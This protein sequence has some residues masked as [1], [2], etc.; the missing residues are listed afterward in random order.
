MYLTES[1]TYNEKLTVKLSIGGLFWFAIPE[2]KD[3]QNRRIQFGPGVGQAQGV[4]AFGD[5]PKDPAATLQFGLFPHKYSESVNLGE[6][7]Y[8]SGTY[9]GTLTS[10]G[11]SYLNAAAYLAQG[12]RLNVPMLEGKLT[13]DF[14]LYMERD[15]E[16]ANDLSPGY[17]VTYKPAAFL[18]L[19]AGLIWSHA[20][21]LNSDRLAPETDENAYYKVNG[22]PV[23]GYSDFYG[24]T[25]HQLTHGILHLPRLQDRRQG[26]H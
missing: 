9:P 3:F 25:P 13:H 6:Y 4:Y 22:L 17:M 14:T 11:W 1:G 8:R 19:G 23:K 2:T 12:I 10:G 20:I 21:S 5:D 24:A 7:L 26:L 18:S 15:L 16:P